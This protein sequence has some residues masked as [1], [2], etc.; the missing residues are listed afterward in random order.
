MKPIP[1]NLA[2]EDELSE[3]VLL[4]V[5]KH[6]NRF[7]VGNCYRRGGY[8]YLRKTISGWN[9]AARGIPFVL[10][11]DLDDCECPQKLL[12]TWLGTTRHPNLLFR[13][14][15]REVESWLLADR[16]FF[17]ISRNRRKVHTS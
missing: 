3:T 5:L 13:V 15:V 16:E 4:K 17:Q 14:A 2:T 12:E 9:G 1:V 10:L 8:G 7:A 11:T 6:L